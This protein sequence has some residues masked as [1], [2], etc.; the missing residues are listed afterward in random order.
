MYLQYPQCE[1]TNG[2]NL[3]EQINFKY[4]SKI[5][6]KIPRRQNIQP[7]WPSRALY[8]IFVVMF[9]NKSSIDVNRPSVHR[10]Y[11]FV[12][13]HK[14]FAHTQVWKKWKTAEI[15]YTK[16]NIGIANVNA[17]VRICFVFIFRRS[18][19]HRPIP[20]VYAN[21]KQKNQ[22]M[23]VCFSAVLTFL[24]AFVVVVV[25]SQWR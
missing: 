7:K 21:I 22:N 3:Q 12:C 9:I 17:A 15:L 25:Y 23:R 6:C 20:V 5:K 18:F 1:W 19:E 4:H 13:D 2:K 14:E 16:H 8:R 24:C 11:K 10:I